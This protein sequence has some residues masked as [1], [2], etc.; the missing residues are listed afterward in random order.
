VPYEVRVEQAGPRALAAVRAVTRLDRL[1]ADIPRLLDQVWPLLREQG[2]TT[3]HN[4]VIYHPGQAGEFAI[5][6]GVEVFSAF[7]ARGPVQRVDTPGGE[8]AVTAHFGDYS[9]L[10]GAYAA[11]EQWCAAGGRHSAGVNW[12]IYGDWDEN[13]ARLR[14]DVYTLLVPALRSAG[15]L[16]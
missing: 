10:G 16:P 5:D 4:V 3:G 6:A 15:R 2:T 1:S 14:T 9:A 7:T 13:P 12:E 11:L 8:V